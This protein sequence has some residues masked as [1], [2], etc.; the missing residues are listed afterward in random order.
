[1]SERYNL[2]TINVYYNN[3]LVVSDLITPFSDMPDYYSVRSQL[4]ELVDHIEFSF[5]EL[6]GY[7][8]LQYLI[9]SMPESLPDTEEGINELRIK[10]RYGFVKVE[11]LFPEVKE[12]YATQAGKLMNII[13]TYSHRNH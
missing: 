5:F 4:V 1:M 12:E 6:P 7:I 2:I 9:T 11:V 3:E 10:L 8:T 13:N